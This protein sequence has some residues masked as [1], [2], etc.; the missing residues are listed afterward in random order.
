MS[1]PCDQASDDEQAKQD[2]LNRTETEE[3]EDSDDESELG[4]PRECRPTC[5]GEQLCFEFLNSLSREHLKCM[6][7]LRATGCSEFDAFVHMLYVLTD[8]QR[9]RDA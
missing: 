6:P 9:W 2:C 3:D 8:E 7:Y 5:P 4:C 1:T